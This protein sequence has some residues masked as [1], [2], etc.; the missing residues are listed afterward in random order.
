[1]KKKLL[2]AITAV[3]AAFSLSNCSQLQSSP[4]NFSADF[5][6][7]GNLPIASSDVKVVCSRAVGESKGFYLLGIIP[8][9][10]PS[11]TEAIMNMYQNARSR[12]ANIEG[13]SRFFV[14]KSLER[15]SKYR[16]LFSVPT[17]KASGDL[18]QYMTSK[19][20][21]HAD[22]SA[23]AKKPGLLDLLPL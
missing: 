23:P 3:A 5:G 15:G 11:E 18:V 21:E 16:I 12:G 2:V 17:L 8:I 1:M 13:E 7:T 20:L 10:S 14:N 4:T 19:P 22:T 6:R 9:T